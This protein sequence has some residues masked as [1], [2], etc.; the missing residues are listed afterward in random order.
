MSMWDFIL[1]M[2]SLQRN[3]KKVIGKSNLVLVRNTLALE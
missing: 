3:A 2:C 1:V